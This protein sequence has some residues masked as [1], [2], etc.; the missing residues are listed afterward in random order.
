VRG[1][2]GEDAFLARAKAAFEQG[3]RLVQVREKAWPDAR[4]DA[5]RRAHAR[6]RAPFGATL[7]LQRRRGRRARA[8][9][10]GRALDGRELREAT[11]RPRD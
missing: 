7:L 6:R 8:R 11:T 1:D 9:A 5:L 10:R 2:V 3:L 4:R